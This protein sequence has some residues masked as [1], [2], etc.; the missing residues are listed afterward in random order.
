MHVGILTAPFRKES[1]EHVF[2]WAGENGFKAL[3]IISGPGLHIDPDRDGFDKNSQRA[4]AIGKLVEKTGVAISSLAYYDNPLGT[5]EMPRERQ[6]EYMKALIRACKK[7]GVGV[8]CT[9]SG[10]PMPGKTRMKTIEED[11]PALYTE[12]CSYAAKHDV[13]IAIENWT[14]TNFQNIDHWKRMFELVPAENFGLNFDPSHL[15]WQSIDYLGAVEEF[16]KRIFHTHAKDCR[17]MHNRLRRV[18]CIG[19]GWWRYVIPGYGGIDWGQYI[20][21]LRAVK[22]DGVL[23]IEHED[24]WLGREEGFL[25]GKELLEKFC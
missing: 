16:G 24:P 3:E 5:K 20:S 15:F 19:D 2:K 7:L 14:A 11:C 12:I 21:A 4:D 9:M 25:R 18:G 23:S 13:K 6:L 10:M 22:F 8:L 1:L 17:V